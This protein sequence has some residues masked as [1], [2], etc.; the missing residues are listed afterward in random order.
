MTDLASRL[1]TIIRTFCRD[2]HEV[3]RFIA[4]NRAVLS[5]LP[6]EDKREVWAALKFIKE[7]GA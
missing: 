6:Q 2:P 4:D 5:T 3:D 7:R 1:I